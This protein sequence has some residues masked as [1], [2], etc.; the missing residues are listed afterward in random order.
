LKIE[1][2]RQKSKTVSLFRAANIVKEPKKGWDNYK[3]N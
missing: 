3:I 1:S 2:E